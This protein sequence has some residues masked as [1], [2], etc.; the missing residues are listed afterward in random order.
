[1]VDNNKNTVFTEFVD[2]VSHFRVSLI[3]SSVYINDISNAIQRRKIEGNHPYSGPGSNPNYKVDEVDLSE[4]AD[5]GRG[6]KWPLDI[7]ILHIK[8][9]LVNME[10]L[11]VLGV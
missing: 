9:L 6:K 4:A 5:L 11:K 8:S 1:M 3:A 2:A 7:Q 10:L